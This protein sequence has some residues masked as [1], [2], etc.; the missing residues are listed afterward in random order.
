M[1]KIAF[2]NVE[3]PGTVLADWC[4]VS[5]KRIDQLLAEG[6][7]RR[8]GKGR[9]KLK[10]NVVSVFRWLR[11]DQRRSARSQADAE[12]RRQRAREIELRV[13]ERE[14][15]L[16]PVDDAFEVVDVTI[17]L[18]RS[19]IGGVPA[20]ITRDLALRRQIDGVLNDVLTRV[21]AK[22]AAEA[23]RLRKGG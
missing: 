10:E 16:V 22:L 3:V 4:G 6:V 23:D 12:W 2:D 21:G 7:V 20:R 5:P 13:A 14:R 17:G 19:E 9:Y 18:M 15:R 11:S 1:N 8:E